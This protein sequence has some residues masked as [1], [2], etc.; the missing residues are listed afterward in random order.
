MLNS[1]A[2]ILIENVANCAGVF[3]SQL[4]KSTMKRLHRKRK[5][6]SGTVKIL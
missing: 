5:N 4:L 2:E 6:E 3:V 1:V